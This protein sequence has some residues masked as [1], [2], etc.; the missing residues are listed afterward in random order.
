MKINCVSLM[1]SDLD[2]SPFKNSGLHSTS[3]PNTGLQGAAPSVA[4][5]Q[6]YSSLYGEKSGDKNSVFLVLQLPDKSVIFAFLW[7]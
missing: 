5:Q 6:R 7:S 4:M 1:K 2:G 3:C